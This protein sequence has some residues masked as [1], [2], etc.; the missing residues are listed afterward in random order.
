M[1]AP[2]APVASREHSKAKMVPGKRSWRCAW[3]LTVMNRRWCRSHLL[4]RFFGKCTRFLWQMHSLGAARSSTTRVAA[5]NRLLGSAVTG[6]RTSTASGKRGS[7]RSLVRLREDIFLTQIPCPRSHPELR[8]NPPPP[9]P[10]IPPRPLFAFY[11]VGSVPPVGTGGCGR[12]PLA[13]VR[14]L[15]PAGYAMALKGRGHM[16]ICTGL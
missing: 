16:R 9:P 11:L 6:F 8:P 2:A 13:G 7:F 14:L 15:P 12:N 3:R 4:L 1:T 5:Q 10:V